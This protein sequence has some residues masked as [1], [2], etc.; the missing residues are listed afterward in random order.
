MKGIHQKMNEGGTVGMF[1]NFKSVYEY[2]TSNDYLNMTP[3]DNLFD[4]EVSMIHRNLF[5]KLAIA[6]QTGIP[7]N[8]VLTLT[9][10]DFAI[11]EERLNKTRFIRLFSLKADSSAHSTVN[12]FR[13]WDEMYQDYLNLVK[14]IGYRAQHSAEAVSKLIRVDKNEDVTYVTYQEALKLPSMVT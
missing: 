3:S 1:K 9:T 12:K 2:T 14:I 4:V 6:K 5:D 7:I 8:I 11:S 10:S 13:L